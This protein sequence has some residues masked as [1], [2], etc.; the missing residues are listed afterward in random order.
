MGRLVL[1]AAL[2]SMLTA[3][4]AQTQQ[5]GRPQDGFYSGQSNGQVGGQ[6]NGLVT[7]RVDG[8]ANKNE[9]APPTVGEA[10]KNDPPVEKRDR[11]PNNA[12]SMDAVV[13]PGLQR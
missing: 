5:A 3:T 13:R 11:V 10:A 2:G 4:S 12:E 9:G 7:G 1:V 8:R 6:S